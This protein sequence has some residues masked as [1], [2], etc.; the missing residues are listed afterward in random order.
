MTKKCLFC[1][2]KKSQVKNLMA[3][4]NVLREAVR[5]SDEPSDEESMA[6]FLGFESDENIKQQLGANARE[7]IRLRDEIK[8]CFA[9]GHPQQ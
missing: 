6:W 4:S 2:D 9:K 8:N 3:D 5:M 7:V 1:A